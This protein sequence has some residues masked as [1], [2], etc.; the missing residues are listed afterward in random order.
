M[1]IKITVGVVLRWYAWR[2][3][4]TTEGIWIWL[5]WVYRQRVSFFNE[6]M[7]GASLHYWQYRE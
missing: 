7:G 6:A 3:V 2:P 5:S 4:I 1:S